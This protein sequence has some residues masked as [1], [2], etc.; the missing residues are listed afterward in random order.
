[1]KQY[2]AVFKVLW[3]MWAW[4]PFV[5]FLKKV[6]EANVGPCCD[7]PDVVFTEGPGITVSRCNNCRKSTFFTRA[8][9]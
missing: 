7:K 3:L 9:F 8:G 6:W 5:A 4:E 2:I 1:M